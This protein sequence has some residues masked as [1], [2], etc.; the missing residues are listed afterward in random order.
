MDMHSVRFNTRRVVAA[1]V[2]IGG[3]LGLG[4]TAADAATA[5]ATNTV[6]LPAH[7]GGHGGGGHGGFGRGGG[8]RGDRFGRGTDSYDGCD[9]YY[10]DDYGCY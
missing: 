8:F 1:C 9:D 10:W 4:A 7:G 6:A 2:L 3:L 5:P